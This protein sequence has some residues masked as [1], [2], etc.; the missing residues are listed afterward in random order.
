MDEKEYQDKCDIL[1]AQIET[2]LD[3]A[4]ADFDSNGGV[5]EAELDGGG[6]LIINRQPAAREVW[7][8]S[9]DGGHHFK[10]DDGAWRH[11]RNGEEL[12]GMLAALLG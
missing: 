7:L 8:A 1:F 4:G 9:P 12:T 5:I 3:D 6:V 2:M 10:W 11:T